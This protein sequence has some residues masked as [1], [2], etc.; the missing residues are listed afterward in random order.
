MNILAALLRRA[1]RADAPAPVPAQPRPDKRWQRLEHQLSIHARDG[2]WQRYRATRLQMASH[3]RRKGRVQDALSTCLD[4]WYLDVNG[5]R[6]VGSL[7]GARLGTEDP[8]FDPAHAR[9]DPALVRQAA[10]LAAQLKLDLGTVQMLFFDATTPTWRA[11]HLPVTP[12]VA[13]LEIGPVLLAA[14]SR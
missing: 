2:N 12:K 6:A 4:I 9:P 5:P 1:P 11:L 8:S 14:R 3:L 13:W 10:A 7:G